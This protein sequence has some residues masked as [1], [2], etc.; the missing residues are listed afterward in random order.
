MAILLCE[1]C[2]EGDVASSLARQL[3]VTFIMAVGGLVSTFW[4]STFVILCC[5]TREW[6]MFR[7][8]EY[9]REEFGTKHFL[10][11]RNSTGF[12][13]LRFTMADRVLNVLAQ[14]HL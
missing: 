10:I 6:Y 5:R 8:F 1:I 12:R 14:S 11:K 2:T 7:Q 9:N 13:P 3:P 4:A